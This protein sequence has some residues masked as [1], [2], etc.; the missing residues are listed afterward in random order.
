MQEIFQV[1]DKNWINEIGFNINK[2][3]IEHKEDEN[4][5][6]LNT[7]GRKVSFI[8]DGSIDAIVTD[9]PW[10]DEKAHNGTNQKNLVEEYK[11]ETFIYTREDIEEKY[12]VL[13]SGAYCVEFFPQLS[14]TNIG[15]MIKVLDIFLQTGFVFQASVDWIKGRSIRIS[16]SE[17]K[18]NSRVSEKFK[19]I[20]L[21]QENYFNGESFNIDDNIYELIKSFKQNQG[22]KVK[23]GD[24]IFFFTKG[25]ARNLKIDYK[26]I[27]KIL[28]N[29]AEKNS[30][31]KEIYEEVFE[32][33]FETFCNEEFAS[34]KINYEFAGNLSTDIK[35]KL[36][37]E[38]KKVFSEESRNKDLKKDYCQSGTKYIIPARFIIPQ[39]NNK[40]HDS[41]KPVE[42]YNE[43]LKLVTKRNEIVL[44]QFSGSGNLGIAC[45]EL[46]RKAILIEI[47]KKIFDKGK[48]NLFKITSVQELVL[49]RVSVQASSLFLQNNKID[50]IIN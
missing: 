42:L 9:F 47:K 14:I 4:V 12:R 30:I 15:W 25:I 5:V 23:D 18:D 13:K 49:Q 35:G 41:E 48:K 37:N 16:Q 33:S 21:G 19:D 34:A 8:K 2:L 26:K 22:K 27:K 31:Y 3:Q 43:I 1:Q 6:L 38:F 46:N 29:F 11:D 17:L 50:L 44:D 39:V 20:F 7:N 36:Y 32:E 24:Q 10:K 40:I 45:R 28:S